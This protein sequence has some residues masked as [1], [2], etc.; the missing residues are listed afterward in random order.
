[1][2]PTYKQYLQSLKDSNHKVISA[3]CCTDGT[4]T[5]T[6]VQ[7][8]N[9]KNDKC[10]IVTCVKECEGHTVAI[11]VLVEEV[12]GWGGIPVESEM[13][14]KCLG[15]VNLSKVLLQLPTKYTEKQ[16]ALKYLA[17]NPDTVLEVVSQ[18]MNMQKEI[19]RN[20][21]NTIA[22][23]DWDLANLYDYGTSKLRRMAD[24][25]FGS[26]MDNG[27]LKEMAKRKT[28]LEEEEK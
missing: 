27:T 11:T 5:V 12:Y 23:L 21:N 4:A 10:E 13:F 17:S 19:I 26:R 8:G 14:G 16:T 20:Q 22:K 9:L 1:M 25:L 2:K 15:T 18:T 6:L 7:N 24:L 3:S 28:K